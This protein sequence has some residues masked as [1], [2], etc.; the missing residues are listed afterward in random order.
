MRSTRASASP[1]ASTRSPPTTA[2]RKSP[3]CWPAPR[4]PPRRERR[5][6]GCSR[7]RGEL[8]PIARAFGKKDKATAINRIVDDWL[9]IH[10]NTH[11][12]ELASILDS[13][14]DDHLR[15]ISSFHHRIA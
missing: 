15:E 14:D 11:K 8:A 3:A 13:F 10:P 7:R 12:A 9:L 5:R 6:S 2:A 1:P 4:S